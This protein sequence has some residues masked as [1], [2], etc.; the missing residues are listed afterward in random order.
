MVRNLV[1]TFVEAAANRISAD[2]IPTI[3][4]ARNR[5]AAGPTAPASGLFLVKG[6]VQNEP[7]TATP[8]PHLRDGFIIAKV[9]IE[10][11]ETGSRPTRWCRRL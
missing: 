2:E 7:I 8:R 11:S 9:V 6:R 10:R 1:G 5:S 3:L 4:S